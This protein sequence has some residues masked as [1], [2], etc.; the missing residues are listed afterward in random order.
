MQTEF[1]NMNSP[2]TRFSLIGRLTDH[3]DDQAWN[4]FA[5]IYQPMIFR[6]AR[7]RGLQ[8]ADAA[9]VTQEVLRR[10][11]GA[12]DRWDHDSEKGSFRGWLYRIT[13]NVT[14]DHL[15]RDSKSPVN[16]DSSCGMG[17]AS[18]PDPDDRQAKEFEEEYRRSLIALAA[19]RI[20]NEF[21]ERTW[22]AFWKST[23]EGQSVVDVAKE[24]SMSAGAIYIA[25]SRVMKRMSA[26][27]N[28]QDHD[29][30]NW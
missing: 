1:S 30:I 20:R 24:L 23:V 11:A 27:I 12:V 28:C 3:Q 26:E 10:V 25:R 14:I 4:D 2:E 21:Q 5:R 29:T 7:R 16:L 18:F 19:S 22:Q 9:E 8:H 15:R 13:R 6:I 17:I